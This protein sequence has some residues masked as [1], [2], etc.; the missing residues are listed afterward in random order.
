MV[1][2]ARLMFVVDELGI[3]NMPLVTL[4]LFKILH[5]PEILIRPFIRL[6]V[7]AALCIL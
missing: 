4:F 3:S 6:N 7:L 5:S 1:Y 2:L